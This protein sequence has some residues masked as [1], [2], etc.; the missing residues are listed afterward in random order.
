MITTIGDERAG[1]IRDDRACEGQLEI[2]LRLARSVRLYRSAAGSLYAEVPGGQEPTIAL[3]KSSIFREW[4]AGEYLDEQQCAP[5]SWMLHRAVR[6]LEAQSKSSKDISSVFVRVGPNGV[7]DRSATASYVDLGDPSGRAVR[8]DEQ[9]WEIDYRP[10]IRFRRPDG[11]LPMP[12][13]ARDGSIDLLRPYLNLCE[14]DFRLLIA[15]LTAAFRPVGPYPI[16]VLRGESGAGKST[17]AKLIRRLI[18]PQAC[19]LLPRPRNTRE[20]VNTAA[21]GWL[22]AYDDARVITDR[23]SESLCLLSDGGGRTSGARL[24]H[25][26][27]GVIQG[28]RPVVIIGNDNLLRRAV[29]RARCLY[30]RLPRIDLFSRRPEPAYWA[31]FEHDHPRILGAL[32]DAVAG[33]FRERPALD[34]AAVPRM[35]DFAFWGEAVGRGLGWGPGV[36]LSIYDDNH[37]EAVED[38]VGDS[39]V[40]DAVLKLTQRATPWSGTVTELRNELK[41]I[42]GR[43]VAPTPRWLRSTISLSSRL[44][45]IES[46]LRKSGLSIGIERK[47]RQNLIT[48]ANMGDHA[49]DVRHQSFPGAQR[50]EAAPRKVGNSSRVAAKF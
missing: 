40:G 14:P 43:K 15:W 49:R 5:S 1:A 50:P 12:K 25:N 29:L 38:A 18:D 16:L 33:G 48:L 20:L 21:N 31:S 41:T 36:F 27:H 22:M 7:D 17:A 30:L 23:F 4:L 8:I 39:A 42:V 6:G 10:G 45:R 24:F 44:R 2:L 32:F 11:V 3:V 47:G 46:R 35:A 9:G 13:P 37:R 34:L 19:A 26:D 28:Q